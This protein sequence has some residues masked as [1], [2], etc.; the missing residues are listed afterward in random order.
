MLLFTIEETLPKEGSLNGTIAKLDAENI[1]F[2]LRIGGE[3]PGAFQ[4][5]KEGAFLVEN[6][7]FEHYRDSFHRAENS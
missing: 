6:I 4:L 1:D 5:G 3:M 7:L 2:K